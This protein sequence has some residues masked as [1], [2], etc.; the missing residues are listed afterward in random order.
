MDGACM[1]KRNAY[2][3]LVRKSQERSHLGDLDVDG[4]ILLKRILKKQS[5]RIWTGFI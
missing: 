4:I 3:N 1:E 5:A 2:K